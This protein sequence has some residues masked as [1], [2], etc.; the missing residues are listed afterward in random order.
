MKSIIFAV[1]VIAAFATRVPAAGLRTPLTACMPASG[2]ADGFRS[3]VV[4]LTMSSDSVDQALRV[5]AQLPAIADTAQILFITDSAVCTQAA[6]AH[7]LAEQ[8]SGDPRPVYVLKVGRTRYVVFNGAPA[9]E[10]LSY[11]IF[12]ENFALLDALAT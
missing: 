4:Q 2:F 1:L 10:F 12:D 7:A 5:K 8:Q 3:Y 6:A 11:Y 9:G